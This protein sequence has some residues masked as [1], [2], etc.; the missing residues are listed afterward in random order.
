[1]G[2]GKKVPVKTQLQSRDRERRKAQRKLIDGGHSADNITNIMIDDL[3]ERKS[4]ERIISE[5]PKKTKLHKQT[6][7]RVKTPTLSF[8]HYPLLPMKSMVPWMT[9]S[10]QDLNT[11]FPLTLEIEQFAQYVQVTLIKLE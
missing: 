7:Q 11:T 8:A 1:M 10:Q 9:L 2:K 6:K 4:I 3:M 5:L